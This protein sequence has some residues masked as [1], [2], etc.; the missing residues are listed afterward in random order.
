MS[1]ELSIEEFQI[2]SELNQL[3]LK[4]TQFEI[5][6]HQCADAMNKYQKQIDELNSKIQVMEAEIKEIK[7]RQN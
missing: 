3:R 2:E 4:S 1:E 7:A 5:F 6:T